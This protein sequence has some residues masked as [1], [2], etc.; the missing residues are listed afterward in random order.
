[1]KTEQIAGQKHSPPNPL[2]LRA[3][4]GEKNKKKQFEPFPYV[5][6]GENAVKSLNLIATQ[7]INQIIKF[8]IHNRHD[9]GW[10][11]RRMKMY[12]FR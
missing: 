8:F 5:F 3:I 4:D 9:H 6:A 7:A 1:M 10:S 2:S 11:Q 12:I